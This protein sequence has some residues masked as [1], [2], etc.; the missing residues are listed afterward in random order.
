MTAA[1][2]AELYFAADFITAM[3]AIKSW[4]F[5]HKLLLI[6]RYFYAGHE[7][8]TP[9]FGHSLHGLGEAFC[10]VLVSVFS[11]FLLPVLLLS[12]T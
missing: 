3:I 5:L 8:E 1:V 9:L 6:Y 11:A 2:R 4:F 7:A 12:F 10:S